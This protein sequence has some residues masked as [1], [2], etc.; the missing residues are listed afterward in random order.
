MLKVQKTHSTHV[1]LKSDFAILLFYKYVDIDNPAELMEAIRTYATER[2]MKGRVIL[3]NEGIN[4]TLEGTVEAAAQF[5]AWI[6]ADSR[7]ADMHVKTSQGY[8]DAFPKL[9]VKVRAEIVTLKAPHLKPHAGDGAKHIAAEELHTM[10]ENGEEFVVLD[11]RNGYEYD[12]GHFEK[13]VKI[14]MRAFREMHDLL[15]QFEDLKNKKV[16]AVCTGGVRCEK[17]TALLREKGFN[18]VVQLFG[19]IHT[20]MEKFPKGHWLGSLYTFD[21][22]TTMDFNG[23][24]QPVGTCYICHDVGE[25]MGD[26]SDVSCVGQYVICAKCHR[27]DK[28]VLCDLHTSLFEKLKARISKLLV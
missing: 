13:A 17:G 5:A 18:N 9:S 15:P 12:L 27:K 3:A 28:R 10:F 21:R 19:G 1:D 24:I 4:G 16:V 26:C 6:K 8:G 22:R 7:F 23:N 11:M 25:C 2:N 14:P 20:Y